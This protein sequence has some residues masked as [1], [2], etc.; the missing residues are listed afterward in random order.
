MMTKIYSDIFHWMWFIKRKNIF[1]ICSEKEE[2][3]YQLRL[4]YMISLWIEKKLFAWKLANNVNP[5]MATNHSTTFNYYQ[6]ETT[7]MNLQNELSD[8]TRFRK[9]RCCLYLV[10]SIK[11]FP[12]AARVYA[13]KGKWMN[14]RL[15][16]L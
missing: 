2:Y 4:A 3:S 10:V 7:S 12:L 15:W 5:Y 14:T 11:D 8:F 13:G 1:S 6:H 16:R 9:L